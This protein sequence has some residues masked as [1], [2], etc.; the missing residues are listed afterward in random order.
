MGGWYKSGQFWPI[1]VSNEEM[2]KKCAAFYDHYN[3]LEQTYIMYTYKAAC[4]NNISQ[5]SYKKYTIL[6]AWQY[7]SEEMAAKWSEIYK[8]LFYLGK[9]CAYLDNFWH[10]HFFYCFIEDGTSQFKADKVKIWDKF[11]LFV[12]SL[13]AKIQ[14]FKYALI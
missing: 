1:Y 3:T 5:S 2:R 10:N 7:Y 8:Q 13:G 9:R 14:F 12:E 4:S 6:Q 11:V